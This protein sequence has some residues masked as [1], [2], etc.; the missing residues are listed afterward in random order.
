MV[1][2]CRSK[3]SHLS[4]IHD[5]YFH[6]APG[7]YTQ[8]LAYMLDSLVRVSRRV[9]EN[10]FASI[11]NTHVTCR[12]QYRPSPTLVLCTPANSNSRSA[13]AQ[14][15]A[16]VIVPQSR[17]RYGTRSITE[18]YASAALL[19]FRA[20]SPPS[21]ID[22]DPAHVTVPARRSPPRVVELLQRQTRGHLRHNGKHNADH[23]WVP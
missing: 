6:Y 10:H 4:R 23:D 17:P 22:A 13:D 18:R 1:P 9:N 8:I 7:F 11:A 19:P 2:P 3:G 12:R 16:R 21:R 15:M 5:L 20:L 14:P